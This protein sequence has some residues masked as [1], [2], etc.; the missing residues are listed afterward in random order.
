[1]V[2]ELLLQCVGWPK[3]EQKRGKSQ[4]RMIPSLNRLD[5]G[6]HLRRGIR[7]RILC[8]RNQVRGSKKPQVPG[9][10]F[11]IFEAQACEGI[12]KC[13]GEAGRPCNR[14]KVC[15]SSAVEHLRSQ[16]LGR[17]R[18]DRS[19]SPLS[20]YFPAHQCRE[21]TKRIPM[22]SGVRAIETPD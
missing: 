21:L 14:S 10:S 8:K 2:E 1:M 22:N 16:R 12:D 17:K 4:Q 15:Q 20:E 19:D 7:Q 11:S 18:R 9:W 5:G 3:I 6:L 13:C